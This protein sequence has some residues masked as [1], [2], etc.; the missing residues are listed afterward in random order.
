MIK[1]AAPKSLKKLPQFSF[2]AANAINLFMKLNKLMDTKVFWLKW[3]FNSY[4][5]QES[6]DQS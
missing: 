6:G 4:L 1:V 5:Q 3:Y 2:Q